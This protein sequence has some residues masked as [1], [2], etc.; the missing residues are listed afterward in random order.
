MLGPDWF[1]VFAVVAFGDRFGA[2]AVVAGGDSE[3]FEQAGQ[4]FGLHRFVFG[5][6]FPGA[7]VHG[8]QEFQHVSAGKPFGIA[9]FEKSVS[10][11]GEDLL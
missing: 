3:R 4:G 8:V 9:L 1:E 11:I 2:G 10:D 6:G 7:I 5:P